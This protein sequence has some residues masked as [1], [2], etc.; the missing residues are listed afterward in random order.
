VL[1]VTESGSTPLYVLNDGIGS[2]SDFWSASGTLAKSR[3]YDAWGGLRNGTAPGAGDAKVAYTGHQYDPET[4]WVYAKARYYD[5]GLGVFLSRD[6]YEGEIADGPSLHR[7]MYAEDNPLRFYD[8]DGYAGAP[9]SEKA[10]EV[11]E[12]LNADGTPPWVVNRIENI[13]NELRDPK[14]NFE[15]E[16]APPAEIRGGPR[17]AP[18]TEAELRNELKRL[19]NQLAGAKAQ[20]AE[21]YDTTLGEGHVR[22]GQRPMP[23][24]YDEEAVNRDVGDRIINDPFGLRGGTRP[25][26]KKTIEEPKDAPDPESVRNAN[27]PTR[28]RKSRRKELEDAAKDELGNIRCQGPNCAVE[29]GRILEPGKASPEHI[30]E[31]VKTHNEKGWD[32]DQPTR[33]NLFNETAKEVRCI[34]CQRKQGGETKETYRKD[35]GPNFVPRKPRAKPEAS[36]P[37]PEK[38]RP[39]PSGEPEGE[40]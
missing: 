17:S 38:P 8:P 40:K 27:Y 3:Q 12:P 9:A 24:I 23:D 35:T 13:K 14:Q 25:R 29:D 11:M 19:E 1:A 28:I 22:A 37:S 20:R 5:S 10:P 26:D 18:R 30:P 31:L 7:F 32:T 15:P 6:S 36:Q 16:F 34:E 2:A 39:P 33:N 4:G 21:V